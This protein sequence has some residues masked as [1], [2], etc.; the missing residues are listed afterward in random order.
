MTKPNLIFAG[1]PVIFPD[2]DDD[3]P[4]SPVVGGTT[5]TV[6][7]GDWLIEIAQRHY[8]QADAATI[9]HIT[10]VNGLENPNLIFPGQQLILPDLTGL[11]T[12]TDDTSGAD[13][14]ETDDTSSAEPAE[15]DAEPT[16]PRRS[17]PGHPTSPRHPS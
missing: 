6:V 3:E 15:A 12:D 5:Y 17:I 8:G 11:S 13:L 1:Q 9:G 4:V 14:V 2:L 10:D 16:A 7:A